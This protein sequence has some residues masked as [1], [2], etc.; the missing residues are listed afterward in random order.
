MRSNNRNEAI[1]HLAMPERRIPVLIESGPENAEGFV[2]SIVWS[3]KPITSV[4]R[5]EPP[6]VEGLK[7]PSKRKEIEKEHGAISATEWNRLRELVDLKDRLNAGDWSPVITLN[8]DALAPLRS[9]LGQLGPGSW[10]IEKDKSGTERRTFKSASG[11]VRANL[12]FKIEPEKHPSTAPVAGASVPKVSPISHRSVEMG[13][14][15]RPAAFA[16]SKAFTEGL[17]KTRFVVWWHEAAKKFAPGL[18]CPDIVTALYALVM[19]SSG[20]AGGWAICQNPRCTTK[21]YLR[22]RVKQ[23][24]CTHECQVAAAMQRYRANLKRKA[25]SKSK[26]LTKN[27]KQAGRK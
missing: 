23:R 7:N 15:V 10:F 12:S 27:K 22:S 5:L 17:S 2:P 18:Y 14:E 19:W 6:F 9:L 11:D 8:T 24:Y 21:D 3:D 20:T 16:L 13:F 4:R 25:E 1:T 26:A